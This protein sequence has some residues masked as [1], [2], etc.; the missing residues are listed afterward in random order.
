MVRPVTRNLVEAIMLDMWPR[1]AAIVD[2]GLDDQEHY[3]AL[4]A[5]IRA[6][7]ITD[8][9]LDDALGNGPKLTKLV[10]ACETNRHKGIVFKTSYDEI[11]EE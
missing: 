9:Q 4:H 11:D 5:P 3:E 1:T 7:E 8:E 10:N 6:G 2:F